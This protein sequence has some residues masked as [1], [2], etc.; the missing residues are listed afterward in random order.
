MNLLIDIET[1][2]TVDLKKS[3]QYVYADDP[4]TEILIVAWAIDD[5]PVKLWFPF[6]P[7]KPPADLMAGLSDP[8]VRLVAHNASFE[9]IVISGAAGRR[10][11][12]PDVSDVSRW[13]CTAA[14]AASWCLPRTLEGA[15]A[16]L[17]LPVLKD[18]D[19]HALML[20]MCKPRK[21]RK[22]EPTDRTLWHETPEQLE[23]LAA[24]C[25]RRGS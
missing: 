20:K 8:A 7:G 12:L 9:R 6:Y 3:G 17:G 21:P 15:A 16:A 25:A 1:R 23:R 14:R 5:G 18:K 11:G 24:Y 19:G 10:A 22:G 2:S 4:T 13:D